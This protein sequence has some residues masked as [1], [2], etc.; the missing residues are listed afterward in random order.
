MNNDIVINSNGAG[1]I[2]LGEGIL[3]EI[4]QVNNNSGLDNIELLADLGVIEQEPDTEEL[5]IEVRNSS[6]GSA[7]GS[8]SS[9][10]EAINI[11]INIESIV[12]TVDIHRY[13]QFAR[14]IHLYSQSMS[15]SGDYN[16]EGV[17]FTG[18]SSDRNNLNNDIIEG[19]KPVCQFFNSDTQ[20]YLYTLD[21][22]EKD[23]I[24]NNLDN[25]SLEG[26]AYYA[27]ENEPENIETIPV[28]R[29]YNTD[30]GTHLLT[31]DLI[32]FNSIQTNLDHFNMEGDN[33]VTFYALEA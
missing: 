3:E 5:T 22:V 25:Y 15:T 30:T 19:V 29:M 23:Y 14:G 32:E 21:N 31:S 13:Y 8:S 10:G 27:F 33:G 7:S 20:A 11:N 16:S 17:S 28:Y 6:A 9:L 12:D 24:L 1:F 2:T 26:T 4:A 18:L